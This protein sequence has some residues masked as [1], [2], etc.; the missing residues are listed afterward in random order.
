ME[1]DEVDRIWREKNLQIRPELHKPR[2]PCG[3]V[4]WSGLRLALFP[5]KD[6]SDHNGLHQSGKCALQE[7][8]QGQNMKTQKFTSV[9]EVIEDTPE[10]GGNMKMRS[11]LMMELD[12]YIER[13]DLTQAQAAKLFGVT[14]PRISELIRGKISLFELDVLVS[15]ASKAGLHIELRVIAP[16]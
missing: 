11:K 5:E 8:N 2:F 13:Q 15:M 6:E 1:T 4:S 3:Q 16:A 12:K 7:L 10:V 14:Q 9:W